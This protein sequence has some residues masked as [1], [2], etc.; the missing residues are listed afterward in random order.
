MTSAAQA[1]M[2]A[3]LDRARMSIWEALSQFSGLR[4]YEAALFDPGS[5]VLDPDMPLMQHALQVRIHLWTWLRLS[6]YL[7]LTLPVKPYAMHMS[8]TFLSCILAE[9]GVVSHQFP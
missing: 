4:E 8:R 1:S 7:S 9:C 5:S 3:S 6:L 2:F